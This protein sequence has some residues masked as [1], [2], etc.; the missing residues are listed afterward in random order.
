MRIDRQKLLF[1]ILILT[2]GYGLL[3]FWPKTKAGP[4]PA[5]A[6]PG[7]TALATSEV[8]KP[9]PELGIGVGAHRVDPFTLRLAVRKKVIDTTPA[10]ETTS[11]IMPAEPRLEG[12]WVDSEM[13]V[14]FISGQALNVGSSVLGW[15]IVSITKD[16]VIIQKD[17]KS[18][19]LRLEE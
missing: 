5:P 10:G 8:P 17:S 4:K 14:A 16:R 18:R 9:S 13:K 19:T 15:T 1:I 2:V 7:L 11:T 12:I 6:Q 3:T